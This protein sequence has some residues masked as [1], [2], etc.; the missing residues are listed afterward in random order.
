MVFYCFLLNVVSAWLRDDS[1]PFAVFP[2]AN[3]KPY[4]IAFFQRYVNFHLFFLL[5]VTF[6]I[7]AC[8]F[9]FVINGDK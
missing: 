7:S 1:G 2:V 4:V 9:Q 3:I 6:F 8:I 5:C